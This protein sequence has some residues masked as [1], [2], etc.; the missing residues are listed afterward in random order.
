MKVRRSNKPVSRRCIVVSQSRWVQA[1]QDAPP[2]V[3]KAWKYKDMQRRGDPA[4]HPILHSKHVWFYCRVRWPVASLSLSN[5]NIARNA[6]RKPEEFI[7][8]NLY[9]AS[10]ELMPNFI[11]Y[12]FVNIFIFFTLS[13]Q[14]ISFRCRQ[15]R[16]K[17]VISWIA[18][19]KCWSRYDRFLRLLKVEVP[20][21]S[22]NMMHLP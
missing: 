5:E 22:K 9:L 11:R 19:L 1:K 20:Y 7:P 8:L 6:L 16:G 10:T 14:T 4:S 18:P 15:K 13:R 21:F 17:R 3:T 12:K 2:L